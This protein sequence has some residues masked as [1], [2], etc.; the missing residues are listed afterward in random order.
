MGLCASHVTVVKIPAQI[1]C[2]RAS[3]LLNLVDDRKLEWREKQE[4]FMGFIFRKGYNAE[5]IR[6]CQVKKSNCRHGVITLERM[7]DNVGEVLVT[8][9][10][11]LVLPAKKACRVIYEAPEFNQRAVLFVGMETFRKLWKGAHQSEVKALVDSG[12]TIIACYIQ[13]NIFMEK[14]AWVQFDT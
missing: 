6:I 5:N 10:Q 7:R 3:N 9:S 14:D 1:L 2:Q 13:N 8:K 12:V 4:K 11:V